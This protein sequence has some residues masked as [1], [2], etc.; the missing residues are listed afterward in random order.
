MEEARLCLEGQVQRSGER[1]AG[2]GGEW[3]AAAGVPKGGLCGA[4][5]C[6]KRFARCGCGRHDARKR[7]RGGLQAGSPASLACGGAMGGCRRFDSWR[8]RVAAI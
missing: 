1:V 5:A 4:P 6:R 8:C 7:A 2:S 3:G